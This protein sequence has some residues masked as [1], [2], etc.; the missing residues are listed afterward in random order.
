[1]NKRII[2]GIVVVVLVAV[3]IGF[4]V[5]QEKE[6]ETI[7]IGAILPLSGTGQTSGQDVYNGLQ[8]AVDEINARDRLGMSFE[9]IVADT[10]T[11]PS[12]LQLQRR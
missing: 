1:M 11:D 9:L 3:A 6:E 12:P 5:L 10:K 8:M 4:F 7:K 2:I